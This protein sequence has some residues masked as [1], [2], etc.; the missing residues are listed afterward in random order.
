MIRREPAPSDARRLAL[1]AVA[2][3]AIA[4]VITKR[5]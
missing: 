4:L 5:V 3:A 1:L 2:I